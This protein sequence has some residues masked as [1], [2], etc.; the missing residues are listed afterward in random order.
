M[1][2]SCT[3]VPPWHPDQAVGVVSAPAMVASRS[4]GAPSAG[5]DAQRSSTAQRRTV[6]IAEADRSAALL[7][8]GHVLGG[9]RV[10]GEPVRHRVLD[11]VGDLALAGHPIE[12]RICAFHTGHELN[13]ALVAALMRDGGAWELV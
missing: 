2:H 1:V 11:L 10:P 3:P 7:V 9:M 8:R 12:G 5:P 4:S 6:S 13:H